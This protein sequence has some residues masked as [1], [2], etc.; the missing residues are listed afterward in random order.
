MQFAPG[1]PPSDCEITRVL[2]HD[3]YKTLSRKHSKK[4]QRKLWREK[5]WWNM[6]KEAYQQSSVQTQRELWNW[7]YEND[8]VI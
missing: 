5:Q 7:L 1:L 6:Q 8:T 2:A 4:T 3:I